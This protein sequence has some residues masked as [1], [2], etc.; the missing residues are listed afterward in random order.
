[1]PDRGML[2]LRGD[3]DAEPLRKALRRGFD[4]E[5]PATGKIIF[6]GERTLAWMAPDELLGFLP[7]ADLTAVMR[8]LVTDLQGVHHLVADVSSLRAEFELTGDVRDVLAKGTPADLSPASFG[9]GDFRRSRIGQL[10][11]AFWLVDENRARV[12][13]RR[14]EEEFMFDWLC[15]AS[16]PQNAPK[17]FHSRQA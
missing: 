3:L 14:S 5:L 6:T 7:P 2:L 17:Y 9:L 8:Q 1:M 15:R 11:A 13:C 12:I 10:A 4:S 16:S